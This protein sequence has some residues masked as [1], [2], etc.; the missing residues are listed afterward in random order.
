MK[1]LIEDSGLTDSR[2]YTIISDMQKGLRAALME[3]LPEVEH[4]M[5]DSIGSS[6]VVVRPSDV[7]G[8][9]RP[10]GR[11]RNT[12]TTTDAPSR[13]RKRP[14]KTSDN[15]NA[16][17]RSRKRPRKTSQAKQVTIAPTP[18]KSP[19]E[20]NCKRRER[21]RGVEHV[22]GVARGTIRGRDV[23]LVATTAIGR[24]KPRKILL[25]DIGDAMG[26]PLHEW[27]KNS[28]SYTTLAPSNPPASPIHAPPNSSAS[29]VHAQFRTCD[30]GVTGKSSKTFEIGVLIAENGLSTYN[31]G[32]PGSMILHT[33]SSQPI[34]LADVTR[35]LGYKSKIGVNWREKKQ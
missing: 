13:H 20:P 6:S 34:R 3:V 12:P 17:P 35:D 8:T 25:G 31:S 9:S 28:T 27:F 23:A 32:L 24:S 4:R 29:P 2:D 19:D 18:R 16:P 11:T 22:V 5:C 14:R 33:S 7:P 10:K 21:G 26:I 1:L 15:P 30:R